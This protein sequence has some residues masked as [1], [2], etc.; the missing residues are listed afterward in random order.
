MTAMDYM[1]GKGEYPLKGMIIAAANPAVTNP[2][3]RKVEKALA[4]LELLVVNDLNVN[5]PRQLLQAEGESPVPEVSKF[6]DVN[7]DRFISPIDALRVVNVLNAE[8]ELVRMRYSQVSGLVASV[9]PLEVDLQ[10]VNRRMVERYDFS[11][12]GV[13]PDNDADPDRYQIDNGLLSLASLNASEPVRVKGFPTPFGSAPLDFTAK[14]II[15]LSEL[16]TKM[17]MSY[18][19]GGSPTAVVSLDQRG[20]LLDLASASGRHHLKQAGVLTDIASL[21]EVPFIEPGR[22]QG[23]YAI[24]Q[25]RRVQVYLDW[26]AY[27]DELNRLLAAGKL[28][29]FVIAKGDYDAA[30]LR[31]GAHQ[32]VTRLTE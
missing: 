11:G 21:A 16:P 27:Q 4:S 5:G 31:L 19:T 2:N 6:V 32:L 1:L 12:T 29:A 10:H 23:L 17:L 18:G 25:G 14:T 26:D 3:T 8:G 15:D 20:M 13:S 22:D 9:S 28:V 7:G 24:S 30:S